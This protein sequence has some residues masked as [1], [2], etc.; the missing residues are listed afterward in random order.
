MLEKTSMAAA[1]ACLTVLAPCPA[2]SE[3]TPNPQSPRSR[4]TLPLVTVQADA[5]RDARKARQDAAVAKIVVDEVE[6]E[7]F[8]DATVGD[9]LR[10]LPGMTFTGPAGVVKDIRI[11]GLDKGYTQFLINGE[12]VPSATKARQFQVDRLPADMIERIEIVRNP[13]AAMDADGIGG[14]INI[15]LKESV[16]NLTRLRVAVG[17]NGSLPVGDVVAQISRKLDDLD[18]VLALSHTRGAEDIEEDKNKLNASGAVTE[19]E[20]KTRPTRKSETLFSPR[21]TWRNGQDRL[22]L[23]S[24]VSEGTE[25]KDEGSSIRDAGG[26]Y[27]KGTNKT[28]TKNDSVWRLGTRYDGV[29]T[30]GTWFAKVGVQQARIGR[31][32]SSTENSASGQVTKRAQDNERVND[33]AAYAGV[34]AAWSVGGDHQLS[35]GLE[36]RES[37]FD[38]RKTKT[39]NGAD[40]TALSDVFN[41]EESRLIAYVQDEWRVTR[42][43]MLTPGLRVESVRR[44]AIDGT[45]LSRPGDDRFANPSLH[46]RWEAA[47]NTNV[48]ASWA[49]TSRLPRFDQ[50]TPLITTNAGSLSAPDTQGNPAL[51]PERARGFELGVERFFAGRRGVVGVNLYQRNVKDFVQQVTTLEGM[52]YIKRPENVANASFHGVEIDWRIPIRHKG[53]NQLSF[54]GNHAELRGSTYTTAGLKAAVND[55]PPRI[56]TLGLD[57]THRPSRWSAGVS[58]SVQPAFTARSLNDSGELEVKAL[59]GSALLDAYITKVFSAKAELRLVAKNILAVSKTETTTKFNASGAFANAESKSERS[60]PTVY[61]TYEARF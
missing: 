57:W 20:F 60:R 51:R 46:Y 13:S 33:E 1:M 29:N 25:D 32:S 21:L 7:R 18:V 56:S 55:L 36:V 27:K 17:R 43:H 44:I 40:K 15:V 9:V 12:P 23:D 30:W 37:S 61:M 6:V 34:G 35:T 26:I 59:E 19:R 53:A 5:E 11:R 39:E 28:E 58:A 54:I 48:R 42:R 16:D 22:T 45:G 52:R 49:M 2:W 8:G 10:R 50:I 31:V 3:Q 41:I 24:F 14:A 38:T 47:K 4:G